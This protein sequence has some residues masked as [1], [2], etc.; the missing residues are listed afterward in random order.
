[1][2]VVTETVA[3]IPQHPGLYHITM[4]DFFW[5]TYVSDRERA[6]AVGN[7][8]AIESG[9]L[10]GGINLNSNNVSP[11]LL[12]PDLRSSFCL[13]NAATTPNSFCTTVKPTKHG[14]RLASKECNDPGMK[15][16]IRSFIP[17]DLLASTMLTEAK[18]LPF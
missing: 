6:A 14:S 4:P 17:S 13:K 12:L 5:S 7:F 18:W 16:F 8:M 1:M 9:L 15:V 3:E 11:C 2:Q 10:S